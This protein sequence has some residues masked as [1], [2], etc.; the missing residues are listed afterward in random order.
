L[1]NFSEE[2]LVS[3]V[4]QALSFVCD[5]EATTIEPLVNGQQLIA[6][7]GADDGIV[8]SRRL[9]SIACCAACFGVNDLCLAL[10]HACASIAADI[11][12]ECSAAGVDEFS[13]LIAPRA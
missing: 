7:A 12:I 2:A 8:N 6:P 9:M 13:S 11:D 10:Q 3:T 1:S 4:S 5:R